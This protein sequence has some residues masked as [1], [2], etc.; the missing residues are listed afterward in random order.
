[1]P[2]G[3]ALAGLDLHFLEDPIQVGLRPGTSIRRHAGGRIPAMVILKRSAVFEVFMAESVTTNY[4]S[5]GG[6]M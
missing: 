4:G 6:A 3:S 5:S 2:A 1:M